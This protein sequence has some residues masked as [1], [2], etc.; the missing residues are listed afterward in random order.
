MKYIHTHLPMRQM[1][2]S[3]TTEIRIKLLNC[4]HGNIL[5]MILNS[6]FASYYLKKKLIKGA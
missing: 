1:S 5:V 6:N 3:K 4:V 2:T